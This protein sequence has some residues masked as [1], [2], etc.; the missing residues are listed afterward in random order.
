M[1]RLLGERGE[2]GIVGELAPEARLMPV[3]AGARAL[4]HVKKAAPT[5]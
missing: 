4:R 5:N 2:S 1:V 3:R